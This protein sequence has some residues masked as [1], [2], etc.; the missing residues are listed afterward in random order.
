MTAEIRLRAMSLLLNDA[1]ILRRENSA[2]RID[3]EIA[4]AEL[5]G[6]NLAHLGADH[7]RTV[8][9]SIPD[10]NQAVVALVE[11]VHRAFDVGE[12][13]QAAA[14]LVHGLCGMRD[15]DDHDVEA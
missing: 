9:L 1:P 11:P 15:H 2:L 3:H 6:A 13:D 10:H 14:L 8:L 12:P 5:A 7:P 4:A